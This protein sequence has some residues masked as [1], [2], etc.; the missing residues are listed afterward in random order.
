MRLLPAARVFVAACLLF[1]PV[2]SYAAGKQV[3]ADTKIPLRMEEL[4]NVTVSHKDQKIAD[5]E[6]PGELNLSLDLRK[7][8]QKEAALSFGA[9]GGLARRN[10]YIMERLKSHEPTLDK[11]FDFRQLL[12]QAPS[13]LMIEPPII[14]EAD[15]ALTIKPD[16][17]EAAVADRI[18][19]ISKQAKIVTAPRNWRHYLVQDWTNVPP[20]PRVLWPKNA[21]EQASWDGWIEQ[22]W[23]EGYSQADQM[24]EANINRLV[25][26][27]SGMIRYRMLVTQGM[28]SKPYAMH[29]DRGV[30]GQPQKEMRIGDRALRITGPS[31][32]QI[33]ADSWKPADR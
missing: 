3:E 9:R 6:I 25:A 1:A 2:A 27:F 12:I 23:K 14:R 10:F 28:V 20:P 11:V 21:A 13:G 18:Y 15:D 7:D 31:Q 22:G 5:D 30:T 29:E 26:D 4:Q 19:N 32:F 17:I 33:R 8:A 16:G 24:F